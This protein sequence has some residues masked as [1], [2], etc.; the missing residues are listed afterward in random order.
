MLQ[1]FCGI[2]AHYV[3]ASATAG[4]A[5]GSLV[6]RVKIECKVDIVGSTPV[7]DSF[8]QFDTHKKSARAQVC[9]VR[10]RSTGIESLKSGNA[11]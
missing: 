4:V 10:C 3:R 7:R 9:E 2:D 5:G 6:A 11:E 1:S 8:L